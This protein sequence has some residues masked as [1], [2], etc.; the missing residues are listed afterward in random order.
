MLAAARH[1]GLPAASLLLLVCL[2]IVELWA[3]SSSVFSSPGG[4]A[5]TR[6]EDG[7]RIYADE[8][9]ERERDCSK[10]VEPQECHKGRRR[11]PKKEEDIFDEGDQLGGKAGSAWIPSNL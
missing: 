8:E 6:V 11:L 7:N 10:C 5:A 3:A 4:R 2:V 9:R 1:G